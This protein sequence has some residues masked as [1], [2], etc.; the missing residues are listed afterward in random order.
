MD[1][2]GSQ[3]PPEQGMTPSDA[4]TIAK[5][6]PVKLTSLDEA[7]R[8]WRHSYTHT[9]RILDVFA[10]VLH[11][12][13]E[14]YEEYPDAL[15]STEYQQHIH[16]PWIQTLQCL[17][18]PEAFRYSD[19]ES[20]QVA[21]LM[22]KQDPVRI[23]FEL[24]SH[25]RQDVFGGN[26]YD[27]VIDLG[28]GYTKVKRGLKWLVD[29]A[30]LILSEE[31]QWSKEKDI[32]TANLTAVATCGPVYGLAE[33][34]PAL[35]H[36]H[37]LF[38]PGGVLWSVMEVFTREPG[39]FSGIVGILDMVMQQTFNVALL[40]RYSYEHDDRSSNQKP[41]YKW[42]AMGLEQAR[43]KYIYSVECQ[44]PQA[45]MPYHVRDGLKN[46]DFIGLWDAIWE[47]AY[48]MSLDFD[49]HP[50]DLEFN[51][52]LWVME[53]MRLPSSDPRPWIPR[54]NVAL[55]TERRC[56]EYDQRREGGLIIAPGDFYTPAGDFHIPNFANKIDVEAIL[57][58]RGPRFSSTGRGHRFYDEDDDSDTSDA[59]DEEHAFPDFTVDDTASVEPYGPTISL[60]DL[61]TDATTIPED[62]C[63]TICME[64]HVDGTRRSETVKLNSC[65]HLFHYD[66][67]FE[68]LNGTSSNSNLCPEC[69]IQFSEQ[70]RPVRPVQ[71]ASVSS[72]ESGSTWLVSTSDD[73]EDEEERSLEPFSQ[74]NRAD[75]DAVNET[76]ETSA[77]GDTAAQPA[78]TGESVLEYMTR[79]RGFIVYEGDANRGDDDEEEDNEHEDLNDSH[80]T[81]SPTSSPDAGLGDS[82]E[83]V[84]VPAN[85]RRQNRILSIDYSATWDG[86]AFSD[87][88]NDEDEEGFGE[89]II[90][91]DVS[92]QWYGY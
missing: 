16:A 1:D 48:D 60:I 9:D 90:D 88:P 30:T 49:S 92:T 18:D 3:P 53:Q 14:C 80:D 28:R 69:R 89:G 40:F 86:R 62:Q 72:S 63:C 6:L 35:D 42:Y 11:R 45:L 22:A 2:A 46:I 85:T 58:S 83:N 38:G 91:E 37:E 7:L 25:V 81:S 67:I 21:Q 50:L 15:P 27:V 64:D 43:T 33:S 79:R 65:G 84:P 73:F 47:K 8:P 39:N 54:A 56:K 23:W 75:G 66:C 68:W 52:F 59:D 13:Y 87:G 19:P 74:Q 71:P 29:C 41:A 4:R 5:D 26:P 20:L 24:D 77:H 12:V 10:S 36:T 78:V 51:M 57:R 44:D 82:Q 34:N 76:E 32:A 17:R 61:A 70:R 31:S 55:I